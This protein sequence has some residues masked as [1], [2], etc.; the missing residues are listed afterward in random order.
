MSCAASRSLSSAS[1]SDLMRSTRIGCSSGACCMRCSG[2]RVLRI[3]E[4]VLEPE[5]PA[6]RLPVPDGIEHVQADPAF[7]RSPERPDEH[8][9]QALAR[10]VTRRLDAED[11]RRDEI[12]GE[13]PHRGAEQ[14]H[15]DDGR[16][17]GAFALVE[18]GRHAPREIR[19]ARRIAERTARLHELATRGREHVRKPTAG[20]VRDR[21]EAPLIGVGTLEPLAGTDRVHAAGIHG[22]DVVGVER[23]L[24][25]RRREEVRDEHVGPFDQPVERGA[26][27]RVAQVDRDAALVAVELLEEEV[28]V[29]GVG[30]ESHRHD[31]PQGIAGGSLDLDHVGAPLGE[32]RRR[33]RYEPVLGHFQH[34]HAVHYAHRA[35]LRSAAG[36]RQERRAVIDDREHWSSAPCTMI[37]TSDPMWSKPSPTVLP[38][39]KRAWMPSRMIAS[40]YAA[41]AS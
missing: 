17:P 5:C 38:I 19:A 33:R 13:R 35:S 26:S 4:K 8:A 12:V 29:A 40:L 11:R 1:G 6:G 20:P 30:D 2:R 24:R 22:P 9:A 16:L 21:V 36:S 39:K 28:E 27:F 15:V 34:L 3:V 37:S 32:D 18:R 7:V 41:S 25:A 10:D 23:E 14:R 31:L